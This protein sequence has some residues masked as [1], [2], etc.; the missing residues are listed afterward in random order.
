MEEVM[1]ELINK[2]KILEF[3]FNDSSKFF[4]FQL[5]SIF[6]YSDYNSFTSLSLLSINI[7]EETDKLLKDF[8][9]KSQNL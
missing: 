6:D 2:K 9:N 4:L 5:R 1:I 7:D 3:E 8:I